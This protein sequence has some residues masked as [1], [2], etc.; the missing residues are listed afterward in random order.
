[1]FSRGLGT[2][3]AEKRYDKS[4]LVPEN[5]KPAPRAKNFLAPL[6]SLSLKYPALK[7]KESS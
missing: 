5:L 2:L 6:S 1:V 3:E 4:T 7:A